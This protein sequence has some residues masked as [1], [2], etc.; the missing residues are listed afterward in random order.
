MTV[1]ALS[2]TVVGL[3]RNV[4]KPYLIAAAVCALIGVVL[5][6]LALLTFV[7]RT[8]GTRATMEGALVARTLFLRKLGYVTISQF[9]IVFALGGAAAILVFAR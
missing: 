6:Q 8:P 5:A 2:L 4:D 3:A 9:F 7:G 1:G